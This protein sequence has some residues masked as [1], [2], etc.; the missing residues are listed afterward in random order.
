MKWMSTKDR[1]WEDNKLYLIQWDNEFHIGSF[2]KGSDGPW[3]DTILLERT[4]MKLKHSDYHVWYTELP[5][6]L[7]Q[8]IK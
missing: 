2:E 5:E 1:S 6:M 4:G 7:P 8:E 3:D